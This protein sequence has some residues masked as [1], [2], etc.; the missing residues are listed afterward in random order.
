MATYIMATST[1][2]LTH[3]ILSA[4]SAQ[5][6]P[7]KPLIKSSEETILEVAKFLS[8]KRG[9]AA[10]LT[11]ASGGLA[12]IIT[13]NDICRRVVAQSLDVGSSV[14]SVMTANPK[15]VAMNDDGMDALGVMIENHFRHLPVVD[16]S[17]AVVGL[18]DIAKCLYD[19]ISKLEKSSKS[20]GN[21]NSNKVDESLKQMT[22]N[23]ANVGSAQAQALQSLLGP[24]MKQAFGAESSIPT[25]RTILMNKTATVVKPSANVRGER[26]KRTSF[27]EDENT[28]DESC[29]NGYRRL[30]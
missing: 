4:R 17:G 6:R 23:L 10:L 12:G 3:S 11:D 13:D 16:E 9:D 8:Q 20:G 26:E 30:Q 25:L 7:K 14:S 5:L 19:A 18:L 29:E 15:C 24:L 27:E 1:T 28:R 22:A 2:K 21:D